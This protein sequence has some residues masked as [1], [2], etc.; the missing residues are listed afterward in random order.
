MH[1]SRLILKEIL[2]Y[3]YDPTLYTFLKLYHVKTT[4]LEFIPDQYGKI[5][6]II[7]DTNQLETTPQLTPWLAE[8]IKVRF[9]ETPDGSTLALEQAE[10]DPNC[11]YYAKNIKQVNNCL[12][13]N[14]C[15][16]N[17]PGDIINLPFAH[18][19][20]TI[21]HDRS[22]IKVLDQ[23]WLDHGMRVVF[24][25]NPNNESAVQSSPLNLETKYFIKDILPDNL[26][27]ISSNQ[28]F[29]NMVNGHFSNFIHFNTAL[30]TNFDMYNDHTFI[31]GVSEDEVIMLEA[32]IDEKIVEFKKEFGMNELW[33]PFHI[34][35]NF[36]EY[37]NDTSIVVI[38]E[39]ESN[40]YVSVNLNFYNSDGTFR[41]E[42][43]FNTASEFPNLHPMVY[44]TGTLWNFS[45]D[46]TEEQ[47]SRFNFMSRTYPEYIYYELYTTNPN[48]LVPASNLIFEFGE[49][50][51]RFGVYV[52]EQNIT[53]TYIP[54]II[55]EYITAL[56]VIA[57]YNGIIYRQIP[58]NNYYIGPFLAEENHIIEVQLDLEC[59]FEIGDTIKFS[60]HPDSADACF[61]AG[62]DPT[63]NYFI[64]EIL[65]DTEFTF[66]ETLGG[67]RKTIPFCNFQFFLTIERNIYQMVEFLPFIPQ[68]SNNR[69]LRKYLKPNLPIQF[70]NPEDSTNALLQAELD[71]DTIYYVKEIEN[72]IEGEI[73][74]QVMGIDFENV[75]SINDKNGWLY[76]DM[77]VMFKNMPDSVTAL[78]EAELDENRIYYIKNVFVNGF[79][80]ISETLGGPVKELPYSNFYFTIIINVARTEFTI[81]ETIDGP[82]RPVPYSN[83]Q[84]EI[85]HKV[86]EIE[87]NDTRWFRTNMPVKFSVYQD[88]TAIVTA[89]LNTDDTFYIKD[90]VNK[91]RMK[92]TTV[93]DGPEVELT[94]VFTK[95]FIKHNTGNGY[96]FSSYIGEP[97]I[98]QQENVPAYV[99]YNE[100][101]ELYDRITLHSTDLSV[102]TNASPYEHNFNNVNL[103]FPAEPSFWTQYFENEEI[104]KW[105]LLPPSPIWSPDYII[106]IISTTKTIVIPPT[107]EDLLDPNYVPIEEIIDIFAV[108]GEDRNGTFTEEEYRNLVFYIGDKIQF[109]IDQP[110]LN[111]DP[112]WIQTFVNKYGKFQAHGSAGN[113]TSTIQWTITK[114]ITHYYHSITDLTKQGTISILPPAS[115]DTSPLNPTYQDQDLRRAFDIKRPLPL[116]DLNN[117]FVYTFEVD[118]TTIDRIKVNLDL[119][120]TNNEVKIFDT[121]REG[122]LTPVAYLDKRWI[123]PTHQVLRILQLQG[124]K[125]IRISDEGHMMITVRSPN[126]I[127]NYIFNGTLKQ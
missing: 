111:T 6:K 18:F 24:E 65:S 89:G 27:R 79:I 17:L 76:E 14:I 114:N 96:V 93:P 25:N 15:K 47:S 29:L 41:D 60:N 4:V 30:N 34:L 113:G 37:P 10:I 108:S 46:V 50:E 117:K 75:L 33:K 38:N 124:D 120:S 11:Y 77:E 39:I 28:F 116:T 112:F 59:S 19:D 84:F 90:I 83:F 123:Y 70:R 35:D 100:Q 9:A 3:T 86:N 1:I 53:G 23:S 115:S 42:Y 8:G 98:A 99:L 66:S 16:S 88:A 104:Y 58:F 20:F 55:D 71:A 92:I 107:E 7:P 95:F 78:E 22:Y 101:P 102:I 67:Q 26:I 118:Q 43:K 127:Y 121:D 122:Y 49:P 44:H 94:D 80:T 36:Q 110:T 52:V 97:K 91:N 82:V 62:L 45:F 31:E 87:I 2:D 13:F 81:T 73:P 126:G 61:Q 119:T 21:I 69:E 40:E 106:D 68:E 48:P 54:K 56:D 72:L 103:P 85:Y 32:Q 57:E 12:R 125:V 105:S 5:I 74:L 51:Y 64:K 109:N 63:K